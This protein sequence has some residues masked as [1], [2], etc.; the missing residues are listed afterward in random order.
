MKLEDTDRKIVGVL[1][2]NSRL[3]LRQISKKV[4]VSVATVMHHINRLEREGII[5]KYTSKI[6]YGL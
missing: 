2:E 5:K 6:D 3:S 1:L 4:D